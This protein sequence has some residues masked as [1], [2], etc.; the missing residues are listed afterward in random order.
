MGRHVGRHEE[1][2][3]VAIMMFL[4]SPGGRFPDPHQNIMIAKHV[5]P[6]AFPSGYNQGNLRQGYFSLHISK[7]ISTYLYVWSVMP[8]D[9]A[10]SIVY[11]KTLPGSTTDITH[12][13]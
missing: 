1:A 3:S 11:A 2:N 5:F 13:A 9:G 4:F 10:F 6:H 7:K 12:Y 8:G